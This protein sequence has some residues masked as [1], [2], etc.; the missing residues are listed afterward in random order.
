MAM[1]ESLA[2][3]ELDV[4]CYPLIVVVLVPRR[5]FSCRS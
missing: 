3:R 4:Q 2:R 1:S 5:R